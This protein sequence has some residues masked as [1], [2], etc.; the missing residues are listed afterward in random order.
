MFLLVMLALYASY[1][2]CN[3]RAESVCKSGIHTLSLE[4]QFRI[5]VLSGSPSAVQFRAVACI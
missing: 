1:I 4:L 3:I 5:I 2:W